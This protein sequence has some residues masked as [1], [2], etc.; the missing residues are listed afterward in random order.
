[1]FFIENE[2]KL[3]YTKN[4]LCQ[5]TNIA[6]CQLTIKTPHPHKPEIISE[7]VIQ[8]IFS[9]YFLGLIPKYQITVRDYKSGF[10]MVGYSF[11]KDSTSIGIF[12]A[13]V[14]YCL[15]KCGTDT[16]TLHF[17]S[18]NGSEFRILGKKHGLSLYEEILINFNIKYK[19]IPVARPTFN[20]DVESFHGT[21]ERELYDL[22]KFGCLDIFM[23]KVWFYMVWYNCYRKNR[24]KGHKSPLT[25]INDYFTEI[26]QPEKSKKM[27]KLL[28]S[29]PILV[30]K[31]IDILELVKGGGEVR[32]S[33][34][35]NDSISS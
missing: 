31:Y 30:D 20:S 16:T 28:T 11:T 10:S 21:I 3:K 15:Q 6:F 4:R 13:Y 27:N 22:E 32:W 24:N 12:V 7:P 19:F 5:S 23:S 33:P 18:D 34:P 2:S 26:N 35:K 29:P 17:Q 25:I 9:D 8:N 1:M 14:V